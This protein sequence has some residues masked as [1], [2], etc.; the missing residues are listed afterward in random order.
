MMMR[1]NRHTPGVVVDTNEK[2]QEAMRVNLGVRIDNVVRYRIQN[3]VV[4]CV[5]KHHIHNRLN[6]AMNVRHTK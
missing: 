4:Q 5:E 3:G 1:A 6:L 2:R